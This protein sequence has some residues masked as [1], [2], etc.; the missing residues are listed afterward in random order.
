MW[1]GPWP[2]AALRVDWVWSPAALRP[3][4]GWDAMGWG[5]LGWDGVELGM[6]SVLGGLAACLGRH[7]CSYFCI[8][9]YFR[10][11][12][13]SVFLQMSNSLTMMTLS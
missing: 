7:F 1:P 12:N 9:K 2:G 8:S 10:E 3:G 6:R 11:C 5:R 4:P 13:T